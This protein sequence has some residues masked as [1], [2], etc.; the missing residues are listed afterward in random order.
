MIRIANIICFSSNVFPV[1]VKWD[2]SNISEAILDWVFLGLGQDSRLLAT[3]YWQILWLMALFANEIL[4]GVEFTSASL[5]WASLP[6][7]INQDHCL[8]YLMD[9]SKP[10]SVQKRDQHTTNEHTN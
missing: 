6:S 2:C 5:Q 1:S 10:P 9:E 8:E 4:F 7:S 3:V